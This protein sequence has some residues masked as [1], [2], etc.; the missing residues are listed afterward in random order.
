M[1]SWATSIC[2]GYGEKINI[3]VTHWLQ[4]T[5]GYSSELF[6]ISPV[7][8]RNSICKKGFLLCSVFLYHY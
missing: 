1:T 5:L 3:A 2:V 4:G 6:E 8:E 7:F